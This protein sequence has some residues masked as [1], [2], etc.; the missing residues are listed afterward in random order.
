MTYQIRGPM[1]CVICGEAKT[2]GRKLCMRCYHVAHRKGD[3]HKFP[4]VGP[5]DVFENRIDKSGSCWLW[6][7]TKNGYGYGIFLMPG[8]RQVRAHRYSYE[9]FIGKIPRGKIVMHTCDNPPCVNPKHLRLGTK[10]DNN[11]DTAIKRR[12]NY[13][14]DHWNG[15]LSAA[16]I[17]MIRESNLTG[18]ELAAMFQMSASYLLAVKR[19]DERS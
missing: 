18:I 11:K 3:L 13:G 1:P 7:G 10:A 9:Y 2:I 4:P 8:E 5:E 16:D 17:H 19:G 6:M 12:H 14:L 15:K